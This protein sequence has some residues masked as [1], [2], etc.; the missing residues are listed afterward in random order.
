M[1]ARVAS[2][3]GR[4]TS[5]TDELIQ[6][7]REAGPGTVPGAKGFIGLLDRELGTSLSITFFDSEEAIRDAEQAFEDIAQNFPPEL[8]GRRTSV[9]VYEVALFEGDAD[10]AKAARVNSFEGSQDGIDDRVNRARSE[11]LPALREMQGNV[12]M[13]ALVDRTGGRLVGITLWESADALR[14]SEVDAD[15]MREEAAESGG[16]RIAGVDRY[17]VGI[18]QQLS[19]VR[20]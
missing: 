15:R 11:T 17:E 2:F 10:R 16:Q 3:E 6:R 13:I 1:Y 7:A 9:D 5:R 8:R 4:D 20:A 19:E 14:A 12:G 18:A